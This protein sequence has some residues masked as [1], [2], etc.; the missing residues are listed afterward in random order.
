MSLIFSRHCEYALQSVLYLALKPSGEMTNIKELTK[1]LEIPYH[2]LGKI[3]QDL[4]RKRILISLKGPTGG[5]ALRRRPEE[6]TLLEIVEAIDGNAF[7]HSCVLGFP[8]CS[9]T[10]P[11]AVHGSWGSLR[12]EIHDMLSKENIAQLAAATKKPA[13]R[14]SAVR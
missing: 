6:I 3:M 2:F 13:F 4:T 8:E 5:F 9:S 11:C 10:Q 7:F 14:T 12:E 1:V